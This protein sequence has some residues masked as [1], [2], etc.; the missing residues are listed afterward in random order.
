MRPLRKRAKTEPAISLINIVFLILIF[1]MVAGTLSQPAGDVQFVQT[2][3]LECCSEVD[4]LAVTV[5][6]QLQY[7]GENVSSP[8]VFVD[9]LDDPEAV[10]QLLPDR[11]LPATDLLRLVGELRKA[12]ASR[13]VV[14]TEAQVR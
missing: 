2:T 12:G 13:V 1:F 4:A 14:M 6:G 11:D 3:G 7:K 9:Q 10:V 5:D 8:A